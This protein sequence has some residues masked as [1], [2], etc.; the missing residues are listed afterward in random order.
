MQAELYALD[1]L[2][3]T[4]M[5]SNRNY[6]NPDLSTLSDDRTF[7][8]HSNV[9]GCATLSSWLRRPSMD[10][11]RRPPRQAIPSLLTLEQCRGRSATHVRFG[12][13]ADIGL[14]PAHVRFTPKSGHR[15]ARWQCPICVPKA[16]ILRC[17]NPELFN[18]QFA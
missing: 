14:P 2:R 12:S 1:L 10:R 5:G 9:G 11:S 15:S 3:E 17:G 8:D 13:K 4:S 16:D 18:P 7:S 6:I